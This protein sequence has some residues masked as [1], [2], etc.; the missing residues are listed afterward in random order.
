MIFLKFPITEDLDT[1]KLSNN[2]ELF[3][4]YYKVLR[5]GDN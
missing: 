1:S 4:S 5:I 3:F 2:V